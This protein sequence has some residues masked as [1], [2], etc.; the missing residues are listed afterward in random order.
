MAD[1]RP[2]RRELMPL[3]GPQLKIVAVVCLPMILTGVAVG[4][5]QAYFFLTSLRN[6]GALE[7]GFAREVIPLSILIGVIA[8]LVMVPI[9]F[10]AAIWVTHRILGPLRRLPRDLQAVGQGRLGGAF[11]LRKGDDL[12]FISDAVTDMK[13]GLC[14]RV[15]ACRDAQVQLENA[16]SK[17]DLAQPAQADVAKATVALRANL[18]AFDLS[19]APAQPA[20]SAGA[21]AAAPQQAPVG[22]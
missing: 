20:A 18:D 13:R 9:F 2:V 17:L 10:L 16:V 6:H 14:E 19:T 3:A 7:S 22:A 5:L 8:L 1:N 12:T 11:I 4:G 21:P 15:A